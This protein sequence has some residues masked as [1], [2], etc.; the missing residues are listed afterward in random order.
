M[1]LMPLTTKH[2]AMTTKST[3]WNPST[4][5][6]HEQRE[7]TDRAIRLG[8]YGLAMQHL[9]QILTLRPLVLKSNYWLAQLLLS[10]GGMDKL[11]H[12]MELGERAAR[13]ATDESLPIRAASG[14]QFQVIDEYLGRQPVRLDLES[15]SFGL[16]D[17]LFPRH[18]AQAI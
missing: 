7:E 12:V 6:P 1:P 14:Y 15:C 5:R 9:R 4:R 17:G 16:F 13:I 8:E 11:G 18:A 3:G 2:L 10:M